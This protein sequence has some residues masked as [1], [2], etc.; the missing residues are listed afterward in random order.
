MFNVKNSF[1]LFHLTPGELGSDF[2]GLELFSCCSCLRCRS[3]FDSTPLKLA[4][5][6]L[7]LPLGVLSPALLTG[8]LGEA[9]SS[10]KSKSDFSFG[11]KIKNFQCLLLQWILFTFK[12]NFVCLIKIKKLTCIHVIDLVDYYS[13]L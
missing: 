6:F 1:S 7:A 11:L 12:C 2:L 4:V 10:I 5:F 13:C 3:I 8:N 9:I